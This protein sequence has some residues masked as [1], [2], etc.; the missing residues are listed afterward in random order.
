MTARTP[1]DARRSNL[2]S[3]GARG[4]VVDELLR[5]GASL[6]DVAGR[7]GAPIPHD[8]EPHVGSWVGYEAEARATGALSS[9]Q[10]RFVQLRCP[11]RAGISEDADYRAAT[12]QGLFDRAA[13]F[14][15]GPDYLQPDQM[16]LSIVPTMAG[17]VPVLTIDD[18]AD[19]ERVV[20][21]LTS[22][23]EPSPVPPS[24]GACM[25]SGLINWD[26]VR[27]HREGWQRAHPAAGDAEWSQEFTWLA[28]QKPL[29]QDRLIILARGPY[30]GVDPG[31]DGQS[32]DGWLDRSLVIR[33]EHECAHY[34]T[35][36][37]FGTI[38][39][40]VFDEL[41][42]DFVGLVRAYG[43]YSGS[44]ARRCLGIEGVLAPGVGRR[45]DNYR[46]Q[47]PV[48]AAAFDVLEAL[49]RTATGN[50]ERAWSSRRSAPHHPEALARLSWALC[51]LTLDD[52]ASDAFE[53]T[54]AAAEARWGDEVRP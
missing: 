36:R 52:L 5:Y 33:R 46:G 18:R 10:K 16:L 2:A 40:H 13:A 51:H 43:T 11:I 35:W 27:R 25:V 47:P 48:S 29:Y 6:A 50:L 12:R 44:L 42:A 22:R 53:T 28:G 31:A 9:L 23:N 15:A 14:P 45:L 39:T 37:V 38:R 32:P 21:A 17:R 34:F 26:R 8:D 41:L 7:R 3:A 54:L 1:D 4:E 19:F 24:M 49:A 20:Q 30:S